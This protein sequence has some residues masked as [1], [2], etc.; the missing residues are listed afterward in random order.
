MLLDPFGPEY[1]VDPAR[2][3]QRIL[4]SG[5]PV[6]HD[7]ELGL[8]LIAGHDTV[9]EVLADT[10][11]FANSATLAPVMPVSADTARVLAAFDAPSVTTTADGPQ[12]ARVRAVLRDVF[13]TT[14]TRTQLAWGQIV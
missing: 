3:W 7:P 4:T 12:H 13:P 6:S 1:A 14:A 5:D 10:T 9:R 8:W 11:R 2:T